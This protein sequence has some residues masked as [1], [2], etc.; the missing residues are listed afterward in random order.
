MADTI[1]DILSRAATIVIKLGTAQLTDER[2]LSEDRIRAFAASMVSA[3]RRGK[4]IILV[5]SGA[6]AAG[7][8]VIFDGKKPDTIP[9]KQ[10][11]ASVGQITLMHRY[12]E[13]FAALGV[14]I[15]QI[16]L[17]EYVLRD[18]VSYLNA[19]NTIHEL[20]N[21]GI[22]PVI[23]END[24]IATE[25]LKFG[26]NDYL[27]AVV[28]CL[29]EAD[30][31]V[32]LTDTD[33]LYRNYDDAQKRELIG[34]VERID[35]AI[36]KEV[37]GKTSKFSTGGMASKMRAMELT[38][39]SGITGV[40]ANGAD[41]NVLGRIASGEHVGTVFLPGGAASQRKRWILGNVNLK[42]KGTITVDAGAAKALVENDKSLLPGGI[43]SV[44]GKFSLGD[45]VNVADASKRVIARGIVNYSSAEI[46]K[47]KGKRSG[48]IREVLGEAPYEEVIHRDNLVVDQL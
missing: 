4:R 31:Y 22:I 42:T 5:T 6:V 15:G 44:S 29:A 40:I 18:R 16:L 21:N 1:T 14:R 46:Q 9:K 8:A 26:D 43:V 48:D 37:S 38:M 34:V 11:A 39:H 47:I 10:A 3:M 41:T 32:I 23:N 12:F 17:S 36:K 13:A 30:I 24:T 45:A 28:A 7:S 20:L 19:R 25:E 33:G 2:G 27:G 35:A